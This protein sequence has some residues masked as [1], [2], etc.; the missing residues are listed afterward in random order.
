[1]QFLLELEEVLKDRKTK[2]PEQSYTSNLFKGGVDRILKKVAEES[3]EVIIAAKNHNKQELTH[4]VADLIFH[5]QMLLV[6]EG[7]SLQEIVKELELRHR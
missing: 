7:V 1:M 6:Q 5:L 2:L 4:E 3:G